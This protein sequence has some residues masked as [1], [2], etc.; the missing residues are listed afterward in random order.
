MDL[1]SRY[2]LRRVLVE[3]VQKVPENRS[4]TWDGERKV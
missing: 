1:D 2:R 3:A 4:A